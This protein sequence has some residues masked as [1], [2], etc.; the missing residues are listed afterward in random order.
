MHRTWIM[1]NIY[2]WKMYG[3]CASVFVKLRYVFNR[4]NR[5]IGRDASE[6]FPKF[7]QLPLP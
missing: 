1:H 4:K 2:I 5:G 3:K 7:N 6:L